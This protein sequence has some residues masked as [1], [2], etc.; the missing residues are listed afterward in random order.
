M[1][2]RLEYCNNDQE[3]ITSDGVVLIIIDESIKNEQ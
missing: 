2:A 3:M 1:T